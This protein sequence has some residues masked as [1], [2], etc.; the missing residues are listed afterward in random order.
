MPHGLQLARQRAGIAKRHRAQHRP[1]RGGTVTVKHLP[2][3][4]R[5]PAILQ[6]AAAPPG[7]WRRESETG[8]ARARGDPPG[9]GPMPWQQKEGG[10]GARDS[11][12]HLV[13]EDETVRDRIEVSRKSQAAPR[14]AAAAREMA[15]STGRG[16][17]P[18]GEGAGPRRGA[19]G[20]AGQGEP[21][22]AARALQALPED[23]EPSPPAQASRRRRRAGDRPPAR[24]PRGHRAAPPL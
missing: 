20:P 17:A 4:L 21:G 6:E 5:L 23:R 14:T 1:V 24:Q 3:E 7:Q 9:P 19:T 2:R 11:P 16:L 22:G 10:R 12:A 15:A 18:P 13:L 8:R